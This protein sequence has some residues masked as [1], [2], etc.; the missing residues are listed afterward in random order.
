MGDEEIKLLYS[1]K[2]VKFNALNIFFLNANVAIGF[3]ALLSAMA[4]IAV[5]Q[6]L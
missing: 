4:V 3:T 1:L 6:G 5:R 2:V